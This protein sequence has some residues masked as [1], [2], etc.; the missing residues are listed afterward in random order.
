MKGSGDRGRIRDQ[1]SVRVHDPH[2]HSVIA[3][4]SERLELKAVGRRLIG[5]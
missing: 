1:G 2:D 4:K 5:R 3:L